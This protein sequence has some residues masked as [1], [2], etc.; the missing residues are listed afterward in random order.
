MNGDKNILQAKS[1]DTEK[2][3]NYYINADKNSTNPPWESE[4]VFHALRDWF[5]AEGLYAH[6]SLKLKTEL[7]LK[8]IELGSGASFSSIWLAE[9]GNTVFAIDVSPEAIKRAES[10]DKDKKVNW[11]CA[12]LLDDE[13]FLKNKNIV[14]ESFDVLFDMQ[15]FH[16]LRNLNE[17][18]AVEIM[19]DL[20]KKKGKLMIVVGACLESYA[21]DDMQNNS[22][23]NYGPPKIFI[24]DFLIPLTNKGFKALSVKLSRFNTTKVYGDTPPFCWVGVFEK[25]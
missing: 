23:N 11:I 13:F 6:D 2:W 17:N 5:E 16:V 12:D 21:K 14:K 25:Q 10:F 3:N 19:Y 15:C 1:T 9:K 8:I 4:E 7:S 22:E 24:D 18:K 20:L